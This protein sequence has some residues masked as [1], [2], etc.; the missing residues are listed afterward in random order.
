MCVF[1]GKDKRIWIKMR[2]TR[3]GQFMPHIN[4]PRMNGHNTRNIPID[5]PMTH[6]NQTTMDEH[7][8]YTKRAPH[9]L[10]RGRIEAPHALHHPAVRRAASAQQGVLRREREGPPEAPVA[11][12]EEE[13]AELEGLD[14]ELLPLVVLVFLFFSL[15]LTWCVFAHVCVYMCGEYIDPHVVVQ[16]TKHTS[17]HTPLHTF[18]CNTPHALLL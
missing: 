7:N 11:G 18:F 2:E 12:G 14:L 15:V 6:T 8:T 13:D 10:A 17:P 3:V 9:V 16:P 5:R 1:G 4:Q